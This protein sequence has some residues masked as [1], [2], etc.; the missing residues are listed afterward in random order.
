MGI[1]IQKSTKS[2]RWFRCAE[3]HHR[4][5]NSSW[6]CGRCRTMKGPLPL[7]VWLV[8]SVT[9]SLAATALVISL[10]ALAYALLN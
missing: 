1:I 6:R 2:K 3:C 10:L 7:F 8:R 9:Y 4:M 5:R